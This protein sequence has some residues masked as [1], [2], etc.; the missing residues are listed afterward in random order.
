MISRFPHFYQPLDAPWGSLRWKLIKL[1]T[2]NDSN[3]K[4]CASEL[5]WT[6]CGSS[7]KFVRRTGYGN[8][9]HMLGIKGLV[10]LPKSL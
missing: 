7:D 3:L 4:R 9:V 2:S 10:Q 6:I 1:M 5:L 8:A